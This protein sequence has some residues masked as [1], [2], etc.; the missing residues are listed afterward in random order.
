MSSVLEIS[1]TLFCYS[2]ND[3]LYLS[4]IAFYSSLSPFSIS[5]LFMFSMPP[6]TPTP[7]PSFPFISRCRILRTQK[8][9][10]SSRRE[11]KEYQTGGQRVSNG[12]PKSIKREAKRIKREAKSIKHT[13]FCSPKRLDQGRSYCIW[14]GIIAIVRFAC[15][16]TSPFKSTLPGHLTSFIPFG[17]SQLYPQNKKHF[18]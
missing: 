10:S 12:R 17:L 11:A 16:Q 3:L 4:Y 5:T 15:C 2:Y 9:N 13:V 6:P 14:S 1:S 7:H 18:V 8:S